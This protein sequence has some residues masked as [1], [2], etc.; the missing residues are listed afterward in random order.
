MLESQWSR[1]AVS[2]TTDIYQRF[3]ARQDGSVVSSCITITKTVP[4]LRPRET[5][6][7]IRFFLRGNIKDDIDVSGLVLGQSGN[8]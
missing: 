8:P 7:E 3:S 6:A 1:S 4:L 5:E 2:F